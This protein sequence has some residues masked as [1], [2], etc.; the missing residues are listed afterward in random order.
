VDESTFNDERGNPELPDGL[1]NFRMNLVELLVDICQLLRSATFIQKVPVLE[2]DLLHIYL[3]WCKVSL[4]YI[5]YF[6]ANAIV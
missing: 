1:V 5:T 4:Y 6:V 3:K 2:Y